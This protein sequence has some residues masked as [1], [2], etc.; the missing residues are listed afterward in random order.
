MTKESTHLVFD[1][2]KIMI[3][4]DMVPVFSFLMEIEKE[5]DSLLGF[6]KKL[7]GIRESHLEMI[8]FVGFLSNKLKENNIDFKYNFKEHPNKIAEK[9]DFHIPLRSQTIVLFASLDVLF[10]LHMA[11][12]NETDD[13][14]VLKK[15]TMDNDNIKSFLNIFLLAEENHYYKTNKTRLSK[16]DS[17]KLR[18]LRNSLTHFFSIGHGGLSLAPSLLDEKARKLENI[19]KQQKKGNV[20]FMSQDDLYELIKSANHLQM[21][22][23]SDNFQENNVNF[24]RKMNFVISLVKREG[25]VIMLNKDLNIK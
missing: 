25:A 9:L 15:L 3:S 11:Y 17:T 6:N 1:G 24:K 20:V 21:K 7:N 19:L 23:W 22:K 5:I 12:E 13:D 2:K 8:N 16:I 10:N 4:H 14:N 18:D